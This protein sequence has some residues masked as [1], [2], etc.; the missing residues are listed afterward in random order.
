MLMEFCQMAYS[1]NKYDTFHSKYLP[2][3]L[4]LTAK[5]KTF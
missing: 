4:L 3:N 5:F 1:Q 2:T